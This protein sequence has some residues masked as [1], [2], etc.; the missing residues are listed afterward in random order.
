MECM[1]AMTE[2]ASERLRGDAAPAPRLLVVE[3][4]L[5]LMNIVTRMA[6][7]L[8]PRIEVD[9]V[10]DVESAIDKLERRTYRMVLAD[11][12]LKGSRC[13][14]TLLDHCSESQPDAIFAMMSSMDFDDLWNLSAARE[15]P[16]LRKPFTAAECFG[17]IG[18]AFE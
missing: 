10:M 5:D 18:S 7:L 14:L 6:G 13:G 17:F 8:D 3:D 11:Y 9:W 12:H 16:Y 1:N 4:D 2:T 15:F